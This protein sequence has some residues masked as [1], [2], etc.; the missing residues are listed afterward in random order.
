MAMNRFDGVPESLR[1]DGWW[2][3][4]SERPKSRRWQVA[5]RQTV[6]IVLGLA[7]LTGLAVSDSLE[8]T[9]EGGFSPERASHSLVPEPTGPGAHE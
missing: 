5:R 8:R 3:D 6:M 9:T 7:I 4:P 1:Q 2:L